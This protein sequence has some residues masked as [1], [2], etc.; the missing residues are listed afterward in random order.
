MNLRNM[1]EC[2]WWQNEKISYEYLKLYPAP[3][4]DTYYVYDE[5]TNELKLSG[6]T[7]FKLISLGFRRKG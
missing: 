5:S 6:W 7:R 2:E 3:D 4:S 1:E